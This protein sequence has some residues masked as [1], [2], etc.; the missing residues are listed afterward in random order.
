MSDLRE[1]VAR[2]MCWAE[3]PEC[4][5]PCCDGQCGD[6]ETATD[7]YGKAANAALAAIEAAG[8]ELRR[9]DVAYVTGKPTDH[10]STS[11]GPVNCNIRRRLQGEGYPRTCERCGLGPCPFFDNDG[12][13]KLGPKP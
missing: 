13:S 9:K 12:R 6:A 3:G 8:F 4:A 2:A 11:P 10:A 1:A 5:N 7:C